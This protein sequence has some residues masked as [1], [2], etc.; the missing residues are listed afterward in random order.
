MFPVLPRRNPSLLLSDLFFA[1]PYSS[2]RKVSFSPN[3]L[4]QTLLHFH[5]CEHADFVEA[6][7][8]VCISLCAVQL[9]FQARDL[10]IRRS[11]LCQWA[12][13]RVCFRIGGSMSDASGSSNLFVGDGSAATVIIAVARRVTGNATARIM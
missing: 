6:F 9:F 1:L 12:P 4:Q 7:R 10:R 13:R 5:P 11:G 8:A 2:I 3:H